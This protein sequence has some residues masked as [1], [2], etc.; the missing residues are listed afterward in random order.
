MYLLLTK[1]EKLILGPF[2]PLFRRKTQND[3]SLIFKLDDTLTSSKNSK[4]YIS[5]STEKI[6]AIGK[7]TNGQ[8]DGE[9]FIGPS[10]DLYFVGPIT[11]DNFKHINLIE[12][13][14]YQAQY[15]GIS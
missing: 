10:L 2:L 3:A 12:L 11:V 15:F 8:R 9:H 13:H 5:C 14:S 6:Q 7:L 1:L 4:K